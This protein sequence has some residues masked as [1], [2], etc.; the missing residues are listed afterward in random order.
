MRLRQPILCLRPVRVRGTGAG[1]VAVRLYG[2][3]SCGDAR[4]MR[5]IGLRK[6][7]GADGPR[8]PA[9]RRRRPEA[10]G[11][12]WRARAGARRR[13]DPPAG[14]AAVRDGG[15]RPADVSG[16][17]FASRRRSLPA[18]PRHQPG[19]SG[20]R[21][22]GPTVGG[23][24]HDRQRTVLEATVF[25]WPRARRKRSGMADERPPAEPLIAGIACPGQAPQAV[26]ENRVRTERSSRR[27]TR[28]FAWVYMTSSTAMYSPIHN[29]G[30]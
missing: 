14:R 29:S 10:G 20:H 17:P 22:F 3:V 5:E 4:R 11:H 23:P 25:R 27:A 18:G 13:R 1:V 26:T 2:V 6:A 28:L 7:L 21:P 9:A 19:P 15:A 8:R 16:V 30:T 12:R 24:S